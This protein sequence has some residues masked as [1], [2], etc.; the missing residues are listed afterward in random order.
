M[1]ELRSKSIFIF[2]LMA[3]LFLKAQELPPQLLEMEKGLDT[4]QGESRYG[5][6]MSLAQN[7]AQYNIKRSQ[8]FVLEAI[9]VAKAIDNTAYHARG[10]NGMGITHFMQG[11]LD[12]ALHYYERSLA[13]NLAAQDSLGLGVNYSNLSNVHVEMGDYN[14]A[15]QYFFKGLEMARLQQDSGTMADI[16]NNLARLYKR[17]RMYEEAITETKKAIELYKA[18]D[19]EDLV[20]EYNNL[21]ITYQDKGDLDSA[22][23]YFRSC[24]KYSLKSGIKE[25]LFLAATNISGAYQQQNNTDSARYYIDLAFKDTTLPK[26]PRF[27]LTVGVSQVA[28]LIDEGKNQEA[29]DLSFELLEIALKASRVKEQANLYGH[30]QTCY[31]N[32]K[33]FNQ[34]YFYL[35][36]YYQLGDSLRSESNLTEIARVRE[37]YEYQIE[38]DRLEAEHLKEIQDEKQLQQ[39][40]YYFLGFLGLLSLFLAFYGYTRRKRN[41]MLRKKN[42]QIEK[43]NQ[44][45]Q[46]QDEELRVQKRNLEALNNF[47]D[48]ILAV[49]AHDLKSP[50][51]SLQGL[52]DLNLL[53]E[54]Q[55]PALLKE[56]MAKLGTQL[57]IVR[58]SVENL[59][60]WARLQLGASSQMDDKGALIGPTIHEVLAL[61]QGMVNTKSLN[62]KMELE[63]PQH[64]LDV[65]P[66]ILR[67]VLRNLLSNALKYSPQG[68][69]IQI[70]SS[71]EANFIRLSVRDQGPGLKKE[72]QE[73]MFAEMMQSTEGSS[74][75]KGTGLG[76]YLSAEFIRTSGGRIG[77]KSELGKGSEFWFT[78][79]L[80]D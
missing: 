42:A 75:E 30:I 73:A 2:F 23:F 18:I 31:A 68:G 14:Q 15:I 52:L 12:S 56:M 24:I 8:A 26:N 39:Q 34:A 6:L 5:L 53:A 44:E 77:V 19:E 11:D 58:Q 60:H 64:N 10:L 49:M 43:Q 67:I 59:L 13:I 35:D 37:K 69:E 41:I 29:L 32:L 55:D 45:I 7:S 61:Y 54:A 50:L 57:V 16:H 21:G 65:V 46:E 71:L 38:K 47:K 40:S 79:P 48:R 70:R 4:A 3:S 22:I 63:D 74:K 9:E 36:K 20:A 78:L 76:L 28:V 66:E 62:I 72:Q 51:N 17:L 80:K 1:T 27:F 25:G 33:Q